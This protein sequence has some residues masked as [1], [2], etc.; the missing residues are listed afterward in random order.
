M[1]AIKNASEDELVSL[2]IPKAVILEIK[3]VLK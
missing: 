2:G 1:D 3:E